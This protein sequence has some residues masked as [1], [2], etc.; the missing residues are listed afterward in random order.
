MCRLFLYVIVALIFLFLSPRS[1]ANVFDWTLTGADQGSGTI[2]I[3]AQ[4]EGGAAIVG[5]T[6]TIDGETI[7][8]LQGGAP[9]APASSPTGAFAYD[10]ILFPDAA[11]LL[12][13]NGL[14]FRIAGQEGNIWGNDGGYGF[15]IAVCGNCIVL[16]HDADSFAI[17]PQPADPS[18]DSQDL[19]E[20]AAISVLGWGLAVLAASR[21]RKKRARGCPQALPV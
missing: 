7:E 14:L 6:G 1:H 15:A 17:V 13:G 20:P 21:G 4:D 18:A 11:R 8:G 10:N 5:F 16:S 12:D 9:T 3:G 2:A 19:P